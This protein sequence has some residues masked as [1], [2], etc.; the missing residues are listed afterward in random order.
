MGCDRRRLDEHID[1]Y[2]DSHGGCC[3]KIQRERNKRSRATFH[4]LVLAA[5][6]DT[7]EYTDREIEILKTFDG[8]AVE[9]SNETGIQFVRRSTEAGPWPRAFTT[10]TFL[11]AANSRCYERHPKNRKACLGGV[12]GCATPPNETHVR[13]MLLVFNQFD[14]TNTAFRPFASQ[15]CSDGERIKRASGP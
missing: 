1:C 14:S 4:G 7:P 13:M 11:S 12:E 8:V 3:A 15:P 9:A 10:P 6:D 2:R 5:L